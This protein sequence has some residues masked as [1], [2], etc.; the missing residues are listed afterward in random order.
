[1]DGGY[2]PTSLFQPSGGRWAWQDG[3]R[4]TLAIRP[5]A[6]APPLA[7]I[8]HLPFTPTHTIGAP[9]CDNNSPARDVSPQSGP[10]VSNFLCPVKASSAGGRL[11][12]E[13]RETQATASTLAWFMG[14]MERRPTQDDSAYL[15]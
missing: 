3:G 11:G 1:M 10:V 7:P 14:P 15:L 9:A 5:L 2:P 6:S 4:H 12:E 13:N 8:R